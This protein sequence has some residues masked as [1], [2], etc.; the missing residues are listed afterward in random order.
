ML[1][2]HNRKLWMDSFRAMNND[3]RINI[4]ALVAG[5][6]K[7]FSELKRRIGATDGNLDYHLD[8]LYSAGFIHNTFQRSKNSQDYSHYGLTERGRKIVRK[9]GIS[10][11]TKR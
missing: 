4:L 11:K 6:E 9:F 3:S 8:V 5:G 7:S 1:M 2:D 10:A